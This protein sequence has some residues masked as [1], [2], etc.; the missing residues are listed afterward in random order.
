MDVTEPPSPL[1]VCS[2][3]RGAALTTSHRVKVGAL[4]VPDRTG[5]LADHL[6]SHGQSVACTL[7]APA[8]A[9]PP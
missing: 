6:S 3:G 1:F 9:Y 5:S 2:G 4:G 8:P 7:P